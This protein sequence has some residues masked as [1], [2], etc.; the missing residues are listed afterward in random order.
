[1]IYIGE[2][3]TCSLSLVHI[4]FSRMEHNVFFKELAPRTALLLSSHADA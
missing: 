3:F 1:M 4:F 2:H